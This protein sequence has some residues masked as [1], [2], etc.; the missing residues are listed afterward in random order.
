MFAMYNQDKEKGTAP[1]K[2]IVKDGEMTAVITYNGTSAYGK[3]YVGDSTA[4]AS[5]AEADWIMPVSDGTNDTFTLP[6]T[7]LDKE[8]KYSSWSNKNS[9]WVDQVIIFK[10]EGMT[11][12]GQ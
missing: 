6:V 12:A 5:S 2:L 4:A 10:S 9:K 1:G 11:K 8:I 7:E 3:M